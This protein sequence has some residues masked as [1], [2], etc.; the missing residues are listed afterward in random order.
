[1]HTRTKVI[2]HI[3][4]IILGNALDAIGFVL[5]VVPSGL[6][7]G[8][9]SGLGLFINHVWGIPISVFVFAF[10][11]IMFI[12]GFIFLG[13]KFAATTALSSFCYPLIMG[14]LERI[15]G[16]FV[17]TNDILLCTIMGGL[18]IGAGVGLVLRAGASSGGM[19]VPPLLLNRYLHLPLSVMIYVFDI[20][21]LLLQVTNNSVESILYGIVL[22]LIYSIVIDKFMLIGKNMVQVK[23][24]SREN[25]AIRD[26]IFEQLDRGVTLLK[27]RTGYLEEDTEVVL[28]V[29]TNRQLFK[30]ESLVHKIDPRAFMVV[31]RVSEV[32]GEGFTY[33]AKDTP[34]QSHNNL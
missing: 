10:N 24:V 34:S 4:M 12:I 19:D 25:L 17:L 8:G 18:L 21:I 20:S 15:V 27:S 29:I 5:F 3:L 9:V 28:S 13:K 11:A 7:T 26:A 14:I 23:I 6:I 16:D 22:V 32:V 30:L 31:S 33:P 2:L 1:M